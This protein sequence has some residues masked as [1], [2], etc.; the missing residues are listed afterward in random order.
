MTAHLL[1]TVLQDFSV[2][3]NPPIEGV[4]TL[5]LAKQHL[6]YED[7]DRDLLINQYIRASQAWVE[8]FIGKP[9]S[10]R[11][12]TETF[13]YFQQHFNLLKGPVVSVTS[14]EYL[15]SNGNLQALANFR[16]RGSRIYSPLGGWPST[17]DLSPVTIVYQAGFANVPA[18]LV[19]A[20][21]LL[22]GHWFENREGASDRPAKAVE[23]AVEALC[24]PYRFLQV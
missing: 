15:D 1:A 14:I 7:T 2:V 13:N 20:Q 12:V 8:N 19:S 9:L 23:L 24:N 21:L 5:E 11:T 4:L 16:H 22:I 6:E 10:L 18:D 17:L 3:V